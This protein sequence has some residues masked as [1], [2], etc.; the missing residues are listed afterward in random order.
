MVVLFSPYLL[1]MLMPM[2]TNAEECGGTTGQTCNARAL[3][4]ASKSNYLAASTSNL[5]VGYCVRWLGDGNGM[6]T[7]IYKSENGTQVFQDTQTVMFTDI[8]DV[9]NITFGS[10]PSTTY[11]ATVP[12]GDYEACFVGKFETEFLGCRLLIFENATSD[13]ITA[14]EE[15]HAQA[16]PGTIYDTWNEE[17]CT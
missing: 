12:Y 4:A 8:P 15:G 1:C 11:Q 5:T 14:C 16:C 13:Q 10:D 9:V 7:L 17:L 6:T 2:A 3:N